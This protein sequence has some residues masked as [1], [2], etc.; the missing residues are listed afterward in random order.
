MKE[1]RFTIDADSKGTRVDKCIALKL[2]EEYSRTYV[3]ALMDK[4]L[5]RVNGESVKPHYI[6]REGDQVFLQMPPQEKSRLEGEDIKLNIVYEDDWI[7]VVDKPAGMVVHPGSGNKKGT[8]VNALLH[9]CR[10]LPA[11]SDESRPGIVHRLDKD[12]SG[13][14]VV[15]KN[16]R[17]LRS[18]SKQFQAKAVKKRYIALVMGRVEFDNG[19]V[20]VPIARHPVDRQKMDVAFA[21]GKNARTTYHVAERF[22][23]FS[24]LRLE[25]ETGRTHQIR[26]H[27]KHIGHPILGDKTYGKGGEIARH[28]LHAEMIGFSH[29]ETGKYMEFHSPVPDDIMEVIDRGE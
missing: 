4:D 19:V 21:K 14:L 3:K 7:I 6:A 9:H 15:A 16:D 1:L 28:A 20:E 27:M 12:T 25:L 24:L 13:L 17:A 22:G 8:L 26:V 11:S 29:P 5:V 23:N 10:S 18:L 2:G